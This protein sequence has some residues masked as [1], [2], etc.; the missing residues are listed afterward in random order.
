MRSDG[1]GIIPAKIAGGIILV[2]ILILILICLRLVFVVL[3]LI[4]IPILLR[5]IARAGTPEP[6]LLVFA[7]PGVI[8]EHRTNA[9][10]QQPASDH[11]RCRR[12]GGTE[13]RTARTKAGG[14]ARRPSGTWRIGPRLW[15]IPGC[16]R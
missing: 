9:V 11:A 3:V 13:K 7:K 14:H 1:V 6:S 2:L 16:G 5:Q 10:E 4:L 15:G 12:G 8:T